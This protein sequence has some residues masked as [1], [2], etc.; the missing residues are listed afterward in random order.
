[1]V[2]EADDVLGAF[3]SAWFGACKLNLQATREEL[4]KKWGEK[5]GMSGRAILVTSLLTDSKETGQKKGQFLFES[6]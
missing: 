1:M 4:G 5:R 2:G 3:L 6:W